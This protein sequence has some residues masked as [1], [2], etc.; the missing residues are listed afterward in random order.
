MAPGVWED[1]L[2]GC[3]DWGRPILSSRA[4]AD[5]SKVEAAAAMARAEAPGCINK[6]LVGEDL[7]EWGIPD[8]CAAIA[9]FGLTLDLPMFTNGILLLLLL[10]ETP[11]YTQCKKIHCINITKRV[12]TSATI[13]IYDSS[14]LTNIA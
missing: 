9:A 13:T 1:R 4:S 3:G 6:V 12:I 5:W 11:T 2:L 10:G 7:G 8:G 14:V